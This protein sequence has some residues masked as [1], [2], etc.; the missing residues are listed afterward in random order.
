[1]SVQ[2]PETAV[3]YL[4][5]LRNFAG[6]R[7]ERIEEMTLC[8]DD[9]AQMTELEAKATGEPRVRYVGVVSVVNA[10]PGPMGMSGIPSDARFSIDANTPG[11]ALANY[12]EGVKALDAEIQR[13][14]QAAME[15]MQKKQQQQELVVPN[16]AESSAINNMKL[17]TPD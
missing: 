8:N 5:S 6:T 1:M 13:Q 14:Q 10:V 7:G 11:E 16:A 17:V 4:R 2:A 9:G 15:E 3:S 12:E